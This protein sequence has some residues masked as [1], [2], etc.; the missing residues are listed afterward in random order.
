MGE[1][2]E[3]F[4]DFPEENPANYPNRDPDLGPRSKYFPNWHESQLT[5]AELA[6]VANKIEAKNAELERQAEEKAKYIQE[7]KS[8]PLFLVDICPICNL[9]TMNIHQIS[10]DHYFG[11]CQECGISDTD[12]KPEKILEKI[13]DLVW[14]QSQ[15]LYLDE[16]F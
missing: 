14:K 12:T 7:A 11:E 6:E 3:Y 4:E 10:D 16:E 5:K 1:W 15:D 2:S 8:H 9:K 13:E